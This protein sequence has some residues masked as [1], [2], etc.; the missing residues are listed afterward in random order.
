MTLP[1][2][3]LSMTFAEW[4]ML[5][6]RQAGLRQL[7]V[8]Q[9]LGKSHKTVSSWERGEA[10]PRLTPREMQVLCK[11]LK[12]TLEDLAQYDAAA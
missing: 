5:K 8:A 7:D 2:S 10:V 12:C 6:R 3:P 9:E 11:L 4:L 1:V